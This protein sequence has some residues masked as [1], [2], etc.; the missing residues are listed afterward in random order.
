MKLTET[1]RLQLEHRSVRR[2]L[3]K[4]L[5]EGQLEALIRCGQG[6]S[7]SSFIQ[8]YSVVRVTETEARAT[9][10]EA[11]GG[12]VW[13]ERAAEF[14]VFCADLARLD[15]AC[16][17]AGK[18]PLEGFTEH[19]LAAFVDVAL[20]AQNVMLAAESQGLGGVFIGGIRNDPQTVADVLQL[21]ELVAPMFGMCLGWPD[22]N[23]EVKPRLP[24]ECVLH[25]DLY[26][27]A[28]PSRVAAYD[29][30]MSDYYAAR[31]QNARLDDWSGAAARALQ[32][33]K[34]EHLLGFLRSRGFLLR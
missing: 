6:A 16:Q 24:L 15:A 4:P 31:G 34:R 5:A 9:I 2:F 33:K 18:G 10:A 19:S 32:G 8:A 22:Q 3:D 7:T 23:T 14:L 30:Q 28:S 12:Q 29:Q 20:M 21:P 26:Q 27:A 13:I 11:A 1:Q 17:R 25:Q